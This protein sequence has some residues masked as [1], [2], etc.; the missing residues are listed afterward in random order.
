MSVARGTIQYQ[1]GNSSVTGCGF[2]YSTK[3]LDSAL[4]GPVI[5]V[6]NDDTGKALFK[7]MFIGVNETE[8]Q[9]GEIEQFL[10]DSKIPKNWQVGEAIAET[11]L[12]H[13][14]DCFFPW[15]DSR[16]ERR[17]GSSLPGADLVGFQ[18]NDKDD[19]FVF[20]EVK[21]SSDKKYPP[22]V[23]HGRTGLKKQIEDL[24]DD[25]EIKKDLVMYLGHRAVGSNWQER[26]RRAY[27]NF[28]KCNTNVRVFGFLVRDVEPDKNDIRTRVTKLA[29]DTHQD[30]II[31]LL[32]LYLPQ[33][34][35]NQL[36]KK[37]VNY[38]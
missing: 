22:G 8:F 17:R 1:M 13:H 7:T 18:S 11:Y 24:K 33:N 34:S 5:K 4:A 30:M 25:V 10:S 9:N 35:I 23:M 3:E 29:L 16:D 20:G 2:S 28:S 31:E 32:I 14:R 19:V 6:L 12:S 27:L 36:N 37:I 15:P 21:T 38:K 26:Y